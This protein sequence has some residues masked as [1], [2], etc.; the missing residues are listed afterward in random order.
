MEENKE[1]GSKELKN[2]NE[3]MTKDQQYKKLLGYL[4]AIIKP[5]STFENRKK[6]KEKAKQQ[7]LKHFPE[8]QEYA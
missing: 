8:F 4:I 5:A 7:L 2:I 6:Q 1:F 3:T